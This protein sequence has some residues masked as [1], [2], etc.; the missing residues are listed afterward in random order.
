MKATLIR[1]LLFILFLLIAIFIL[2]WLVIQAI[3]GSFAATWILDPLVR[4]FL[5]KP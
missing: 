1:L 4:G 3:T 5:K 2:H